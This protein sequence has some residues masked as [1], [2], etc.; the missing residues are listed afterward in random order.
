MLWDHFLPLFFDFSNKL[1]NQHF[2]REWIARGS[3]AIQK[4]NP[5][6]SGQVAGKARGS[7]HT[8]EWKPGGVPGG[9]GKPE[10]WTVHKK[11][12]KMNTTLHYRN[13]SIITDF[14]P[15]LKIFGEIRYLSSIFLPREGVL[16]NHTET[17]KNSWVQFHSKWPVSK[18]FG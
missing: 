6:G 4:W 10:N 7:G 13:S 11:G 2:W 9:D 5:G 12:Q 8:F 18:P 17:L 1:R 15:L 3:G 14:L 16:K